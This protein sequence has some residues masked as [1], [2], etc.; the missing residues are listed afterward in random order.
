MVPIEFSRTDSEGQ[1]TGRQCRDMVPAVEK[2]FFLS[3]IC[4]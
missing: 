3:Q 2:I 1:L 4:L